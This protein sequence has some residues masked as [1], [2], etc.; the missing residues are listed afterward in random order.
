MAQLIVFCGDKMILVE[1]IYL[2]ISSYPN[3]LRGLT[4]AISQTTDNF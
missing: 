3:S 1:I 4:S 2:Y